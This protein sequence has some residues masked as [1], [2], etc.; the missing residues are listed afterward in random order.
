MYNYAG[1]KEVC[2]AVAWLAKSSRL[3]SLAVLGC[4]MGLRNLIRMASTS[5]A[6]WQAIQVPTFDCALAFGFVQQLLQ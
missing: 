3:N 1:W 4:C 2:D 6:L 5:T